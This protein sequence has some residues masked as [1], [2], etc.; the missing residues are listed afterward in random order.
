MEAHN[1]GRIGSAG[2]RAAPVL[3]QVLNMS[4]LRNPARLAGIYLDILQGKGSGTGWD[5]PGEVS[6]AMTFLRG[7]TD[8]VVFDIGANHGEWTRGIW[9]ALGTGRYYAYEPQSACQA[10]L[11]SLQVPGLTIVQSGMSDQPGEMDLH[12]DAAGSGLAS[13][14]ERAETYLARPTQV[15]RVPV[16]TVDNAIADLRLD[17]VDFMKIDVEG[18]ELLVLQGASHSLKIKAI[19]ALAFEF[20]SANI[21]SRVFFRDFWDLLTDHGYSLWRIVPGGRLTP[22]CAYS[23]D[24]EHF[25]GVSNYIASV[26]HPANNPRLRGRG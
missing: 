23:E 22:I 11:T 5:M 2:K 21:Y 14:Y 19:N 1:A 12:S 13:F 25:R 7:S 15:E 20:G 8:P 3:A 18:A 9:Q 17:H 24:L 6:A 26:T 10:S 16:T 4:R